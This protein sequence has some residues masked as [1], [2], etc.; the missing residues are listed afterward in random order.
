MPSRLIRDI[1]DSRPINALSEASELFYRR[2]LHV[3]DDFGRFTADPEIL[4]AKCF[5]LRLE[6]W[7]VSRVAGVLAE[8]GSM[9]RD[10][11]RPLVLLYTSS[12]KRWLEVTDFGQRLRTMKS[13]CPSPSS[14]ETPQ[15]EVR[16]AKLGDTLPHPNA[17]PDLDYETAFTEMWEA[18]PAK[19]R[20]RRIEAQ[21]AFVDVCRNRE[22]FGAIVAAIR[23][24]WASSDKWLKGFVM[25][26]PTWLRQEC[27]KEEPEPA[28]GERQPDQYLKV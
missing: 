23:G 17:E 18:Y 2:L 21:Q 20:V 10:D 12:Y 3:V 28:G 15:P 6:T 14:N 7:P 19:G 8:V 26:L 13:K 9:L 16:A 25:A 4:R 1:S 27:W 5:P 11:G 22:T 24:K